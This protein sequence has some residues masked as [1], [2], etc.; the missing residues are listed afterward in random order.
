[1]NIIA[2]MTGT[3]RYDH[4]G[5]TGKCP[6]W[7]VHTPNLDADP[8]EEHNVYAEQFAE[9]ERLYAEHLKVLRKARTRRKKLAL[10]QELLAKD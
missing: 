5:F 6:W 2:I 7:E 1:M 8:Q 3:F 9:T 4:L 10:R